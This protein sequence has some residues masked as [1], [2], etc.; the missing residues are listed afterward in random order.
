MLEKLRAVENRYEELCAKSE[1]PDFYSDPQ[2]AAKLLREK[3]DLQPV[4]ECYRA[5]LAARQE[6]QDAQELM[7]D[8]EMREF[9]QETYKEA[10]E[11]VEKLQDELRIL[12]LPKDTNDEKKCDC[13]DSGRRRRRGECALCPQPVSDVQHVCRPAGLERGTAQLQ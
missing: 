3:K 2:K 10:K 9:C 4:V 1:Q 5:F 8:P 11:N 7:T 6:M 12:L 13:G